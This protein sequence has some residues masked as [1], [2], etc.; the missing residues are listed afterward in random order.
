MPDVNTT[1]RLTNCLKETIFDEGVFEKLLELL[2]LNTESKYLRAMLTIKF[3]PLGL[4]PFLSCL[5]CISKSVMNTAPYQRSVYSFT[6]LHSSEKTRTTE[7][8][9]IR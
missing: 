2:K 5:I 4:K 9:K 8:E 6:R 3:L 7:P 1:P